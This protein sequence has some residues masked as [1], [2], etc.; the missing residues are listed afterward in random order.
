MMEFSEIFGW[1]TKRGY[2]DREPKP[3]YRVFYEFGTWDFL[4][5]DVAKKFECEYKDGKVEK[6]IM[7]QYW[8][9]T[10]T[11]KEITDINDLYDYS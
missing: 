2:I 9:G 3:N 8:F 6:I 5:S 1:L 10:T 4:I 11:F 7:T